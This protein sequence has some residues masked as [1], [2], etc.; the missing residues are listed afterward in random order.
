MAHLEPPSPPLTD[1]PITLRPWS[2]EDASSLLHIAQDE[3]INR[4]TYLSS[5]WSEEDAARWIDQ[6]HSA[7][8][9]GT[10]LAQAICVRA[11]D[12]IVGNVGVG[13]IG[14]EEGAELYFWLDGEARG[15]GYATSAV[16]L[17]VAWAFD[18]LQVPRLFLIVDRDNT[19]SRQLAER[20]GFVHEGTLRQAGQ[21]IDGPGRVDLCVY[22]LL[23]HELPSV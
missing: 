9:E 13:G 17:V 16:K 23:P 7:Q 10:G 20:A 14:S 5:A 11:T 3:Q 18:T 6:R 4:W 8:R 1:G 21:R 15:F 12:R 22:G 2:S 19:P